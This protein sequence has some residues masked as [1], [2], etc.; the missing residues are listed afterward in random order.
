MQQNKTVFFSIVGAAIL[1]VFGLFII[2][3]LL[4]DSLNLPTGPREVEIEVVVAPAIKPWVDRA[5]RDYNQ[6][7]PN[8]PV[9]VVAANGLIPSAQF[10]TTNPATLPP[11]AWLAEAS[12][13]IDLAGNN[14]LQFEDAQP[15]ASTSLAWGIYNSKLDQFHQDYGELTWQNLHTKGTNTDDVLKLVIAAPQNSAEGIAALISA[16]AGHLGTQTLSGNDISAADSWLIETF[17]NRNTLIPAT[18]AGD[19]ATKGV[20]AGDVGIL[21]MASWR[22]SR[23]DTRTDFTI[24]PSQPNVNLDYPFAI[25]SGSQP[26]VKAAARAFRDFL[27]E[28]NQQN[29]LAE[30]FYDPAGTGQGGVQVDGLAVQRLLDWTNRGLR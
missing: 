23:L 11:A 27:L 30:F 8:S 18:P 19:F 3:F 25:W 12:F 28:S 14:G 10:Q 1:I 7:H 24:T 9:T 17:G 6:A 4:A 26:E 15:M 13:V 16:T 5:A 2:R 21:T 22:N 20:S 29:A